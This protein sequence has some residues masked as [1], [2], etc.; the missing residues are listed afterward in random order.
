MKAL[1]L[2]TIQRIKRTS[3]LQRLAQ[4]ESLNFALTNRI[5]RALLTRLMGRYSKIRSPALTRLSIA[6]WSRF[7]P[8]DLSDA[9]E[10][11]F[12]SLHA[13]FT[14][15][16]KPGARVVNQDPQIVA[17]PCDAYVVGCGHITQ[18]LLVQAKGHTYALSDLLGPTVCAAPFLGGTYIT[19]RLTSTMYHR[20]HAPV[21]GALAHVTYIAGDVW[22]VNPPA[23]AR[24][25]QLYCQNERAVLRM[26][27]EDGTPFVLVPVAA[28]LVASI[29][30]HAADVLLHLKHP[31]PNEIPCQS[32]FKKGDELGWFEH[33]STIIAIFPPGFAPAEGIR[34]GEQIRMG[35]A[36]L[37]CEQERDIRQA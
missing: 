12:E 32:H 21:D 35:Q 11:A 22:N 14:R 37:K 15:E 9:K 29:R 25:P 2:A 33:G 34:L 6:I 18:G 3:L 36:L 27:F 16:L 20:F 17:S 19:L 26:R 10:Q 13:C 23:L 1:A 30:L 4:N 5:P 24:V 8:L 31:G 28:V 7:S